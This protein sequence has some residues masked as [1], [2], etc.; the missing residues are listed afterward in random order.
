MKALFFDGSLKMVE[1]PAPTAK[2][3]EVLIRVL[4][5][6]ICNTD[7]EITRGYMNFTGIPGQAFVGEVV[8]GSGRLSG[9]RVVGEVNCPCGECFLCKSGR[10][11][12][13]PTRTVLGIHGHHGVF[14]DFIVLPE[15]NLREIPGT[16]KP[17]SAVFTEPLAAAI[18]IFEQVQIRP[19]QKVYIFGA[20]KLGLLI[21]LVF[22]LNGCE[23]VTFDPNRQKVA[24]AGSMGISAA[25]LST[26][27]PEDKAEVCIDCTGS[28]AGI[29]TAMAHLYPGG[30]LVLKTTVANPEQ[31]DLNQV[32]INEFEIIG[33]R[34]GLFDPALNLLTTGVVDPTPLI[35][36]IYNFSDIL[37]AFE[38]ASEPG[39]LKVIVRH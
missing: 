27:A 5:S 20:G 36:K 2:S 12:H 4:Y 14:A 7:L 9:Q 15:G 31:I 34:C 35:S 37:T 8:S 3:D 24:K 26:L 22:R 11:R 13:C 6:A 23:A 10:K 39:I 33:S 1:V 30:K 29:G 19:S 16:L 38:Y 32:V 28:P 18:E 25:L 21:S 17:E